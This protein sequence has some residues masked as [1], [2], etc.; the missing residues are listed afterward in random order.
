MKL[1]QLFSR[2]LTLNYIGARTGLKLMKRYRYSLACI[3]S[4]IPQRGLEK[5]HKGTP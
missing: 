5:R 2:S 4:R 3:T 1:P